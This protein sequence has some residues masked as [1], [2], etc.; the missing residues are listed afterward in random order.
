MNNILRPFFILL[1]FFISLSVMADDIKEEAEGD[2]RAKGIE[3]RA[4]R[5]FVRQDFDE[6]MAIYESAFKNTLSGEY[7]ATLHLKVG[8]LYLTLLD[9]SAAIPHYESA[10]AISGDLFTSVDVC[11]YLDALRF[12][13][14]R[15]KAIGLARRYAYKDTY[16]SDQRYQNILH[17]LNYEGGFLPIGTPEFTVRS[18]DNANTPNSEF[19]VGLKGN[20][21]FYASSK[22]RF[23]DPN[24]KFY[25]R[26]NYFSLSENSEFS[27]KNEGNSK[28]RLLDMI[29]EGLQNGPMS[30]SSNM[31]RMVV[32]QVYYGKGEGIGM[33]AQG[34]N[35]FQTRLYFSNY[36][37]KR[38]GWSSFK[39]AFPQKEGYSYSHPFLF[40]NDRSL[41][42]ASDMPGGFGGY[43]IYVAHWN[44]KTNT[45]NDPVNLGVHINTEGDEIS[46]GLFDEML[47]FSSNGH[48]GFGGYDV[49]GIT[50]QNGQAVLG[51]LVHFDYPINTVHND[52]SLLHIDEN[53]GYI[54]SDRKTSNKDDIYYFERNPGGRK[55]NDMLF[56]MTEAQAVSNGSIGLMTDDGK[57]N[58]P[59]KEALPSSKFAE[60]TLS[61]HFGF[62]S[63]K[64]EDDALKALDLWQKIADLSKIDTLII[65][66]YADE[67][68]GAEYNQILS[69]K[70]ALEVSTWLK[71]NGIMAKLLV[72]GMGQVPV[73]IDFSTLFSGSD[74]EMSGQVIYKSLPLV[75]KIRLNQDARRVDIKAITK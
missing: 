30:F 69:E 39:E 49:Y 73:D 1:V 75:N 41:L 3:S 19:W 72:H 32:T 58:A 33:T 53:R 45:W 5:K 51:S 28:R 46:P 37:Q 43:D 8:R 38:K 11:N 44:D 63:Y 31:T 29:P 14:Q 47:I 34:L 60:H 9:Y 24:K 20:E 2:R 23:H 6:A 50:Y 57:F 48:V 74:G 7:A 56:G 21:Y 71:D 67:I 36:D 17:A 15:M 13:G 70:R 61:L 25:H 16:H 66:G 10:M 68:G 27:I 22:S 59:Q 42:F 54:V 40:N 18:L 52:F 64:L 35:T 4:D 26:S 12:S 55:K 65:E 62:D